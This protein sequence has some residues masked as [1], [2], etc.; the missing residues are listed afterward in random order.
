MQL[1]VA[2]D[3]TNPRWQ[4]PEERTRRSATIWK[5]IV[6]A[7]GAS[8]LTAVVVAS[9]LDRDEARRDMEEPAYVETTSA[10][11]TTTTGATTGTT[12]PGATTTGATTPATAPRT[13]TQD[14]TGGIAPGG[15][16]DDGSRAIDGPDIA[17]APIRRGATTITSAPM[18]TQV[19]PR[20]RNYSP[21]AIPF[22]RANGGTDATSV[23]VD[24]GPNA[25][26]A[27]HANNDPNNRG[28]N[29][30]SPPMTNGAGRFIT[31]APYWS[32]SAWTSDPNAG[33]GPF[34]TE[35]NTPA[36]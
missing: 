35:R 3:P 21:M 25:G 5:I 19:D 29:P 32:G 1:S 33:D 27:S 9:C 36:H 23:N 34:E 31:E 8:A 2:M 17:G 6:G 16:S 24:G 30:E 4:T 22:E 13:A 15:V 20:E 10:G 11:T 26:H 7:A 28:S 14:S 12:T 18:A